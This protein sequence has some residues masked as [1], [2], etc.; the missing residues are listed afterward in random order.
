MSILSPTLSHRSN[1]EPPHS[2]ALD[3][4][5]LKH[6][7]STRAENFCSCVLTFSDRAKVIPLQTLNTM[8]PP[9]TFQGQKWSSTWSC[10]TTN[11]LDSRKIQ[12][13][14]QK[15]GSILCLKYCHQVLSRGKVVVLLLLCVSKGV[16]G[17]FQTLRSIVGRWLI[18]KE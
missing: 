6:A 10:F 16:V 12:W 17:P 1:P 18:V 8:P 2:V 15:A 11:H 7:M 4:S 14:L 3:R 9:I 13:R 5:G